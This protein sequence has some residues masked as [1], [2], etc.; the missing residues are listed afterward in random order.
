MLENKNRGLGNQIPPDLL[1]VEIY[2]VANGSSIENAH[3]CLKH[4]ENKK[5]IN[6]KNLLI[7]NWKVLAWQWIFYK[8]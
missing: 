6:N 2:F 4:Y 8:V 7:K 5:W 1:L 3:F